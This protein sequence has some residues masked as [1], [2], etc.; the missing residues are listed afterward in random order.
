MP[1]QKVTANGGSHT[2]TGSQ[3]QIFP[4]ENRTQ[5]DIMTPGGGGGVAA[6][7]I[8]TCTLIGRRLFTRASRDSGEGRITAALRRTR[9]FSCSTPRPEIARLRQRKM[10]TAGEEPVIE[11]NDLS[12]PSE[13]TQIRP[14]HLE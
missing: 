1:L 11:A 9:A 8:T 12:Q 10:A 7:W 4:K 14:H 2:K 5:L 3:L 13:R 6:S